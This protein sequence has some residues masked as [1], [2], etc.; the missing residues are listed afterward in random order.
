MKDYHHEFEAE[1]RG[2]LPPQQGHHAKLKWL[3]DDEGLR[4]Q[5]ADYVEKD[6]EKK[7]EQN[8]TVAQLA[9]HANDV[10]FWVGTLAPLLNRRVSGS[11]IHKWPSRLNFSFQDH[12]TAKYT[13]G[14]LNEKVLD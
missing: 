12:H 9:N 8:M 1:R 13:G 10:I 4:K 6:G 11:C 2:F 7:G 14:A 3:L 5:F